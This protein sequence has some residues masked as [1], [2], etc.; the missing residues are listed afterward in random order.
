MRL[1]HSCDLCVSCVIQNTTFVTMERE[2]LYEFPVLIEETN[3]IIMLFLNEND[4]E[5]AKVILIYYFILIYLMFRL[6]ISYVVYIS[7]H[8]IIFHRLSIFN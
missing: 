4:M 1:M 2:Q 3:E 6:N 7:N 5:K 8:C